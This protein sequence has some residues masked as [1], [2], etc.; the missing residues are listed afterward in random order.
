MTSPHPTNPNVSARDG[1]LLSIYIVSPGVSVAVMIKNATEAAITVYKTEIKIPIVHSNF[2]I[3][4]IIFMG[5]IVPK[6]GG[7]D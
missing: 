1:V 3:T 6:S 5:K 2:A 4:R 7:Y